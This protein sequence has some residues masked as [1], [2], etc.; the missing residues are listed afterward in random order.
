[1]IEMTRQ[2]SKSLNDLTGLYKCTHLKRP[3][4]DSNMIKQTFYWYK[5]RLLAQSKCNGFVDC[6]VYINRSHLP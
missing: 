1:M 3:T 2:R 4:L 6:F 5:P